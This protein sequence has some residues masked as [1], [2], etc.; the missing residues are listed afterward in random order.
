MVG[1]TQVTCGQV[2]TDWGLETSNFNVFPIWSKVTQETGAP[3]PQGG[4]NGGGGGQ[5]FL[6]RNDIAISSLQP[7]VCHSLFMSRI[8]LPF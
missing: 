7:P 8:G 5:V 1:Q 6:V 4:G 3:S 2:E